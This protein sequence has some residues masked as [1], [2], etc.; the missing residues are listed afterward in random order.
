VG[1]EIGVTGA[2]ISMHERGRGKSRRRNLSNATGTH[3]RERGHLLAVGKGTTPRGLVDLLDDRPDLVA[4]QRPQQ[5][6]RLDRREHQVKASDRLPRPA[7]LIS[8]VLPDLL[9]ADDLA[10]P[11]LLE[12]CQRDVFL[13]PPAFLDRRTAVV[14]TLERRIGRGGLR[15]QRDLVVVLR[16]PAP[17]PR[18]VLGLLVRHTNRDALS[19]ERGGVRTHRD[20]RSPTRP[21]DPVDCPQRCSTRRADRAR[22]AAHPLRATVG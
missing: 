15:D 20:R 13:D 14:G 16:E 17:E 21:T 4:A 7:E 9:R 18:L 10:G 6:H 8:D 19:D 3:S 2:R 12:Q 5:R 22:S 11:E 1:V